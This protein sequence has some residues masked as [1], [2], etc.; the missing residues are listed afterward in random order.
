[1]V[2]ARTALAQS[3]TLR[4]IW[5]QWQGAGE[6]SVRSLLPEL[7]YGEARRVYALGT[8][9]LTALLPEHAGPTEIVP[10]SDEP[11]GEEVLVTNGMESRAQILAGIRDARERSPGTTLPGSSPWAGTALFPSSPSPSSPPVTETTWP[12]SGST[13]TPTSAPRTPRTPATTPWRSPT[14]SALVTSR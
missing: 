3:D 4:L 7:P 12:S 6:T 13:P 14:S 1:M 11:T 5:P 8:R 9:V 10:V 2:D